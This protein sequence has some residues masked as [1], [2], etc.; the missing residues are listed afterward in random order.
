ME[1]WQVFCLSGCCGMGVFLI[2]LFLSKIK[3]RNY[4]QYDINS[5]SYY[6][7]FGVSDDWYD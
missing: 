5:G 7:K 4:Q 2:L 6:G 3:S 1:L